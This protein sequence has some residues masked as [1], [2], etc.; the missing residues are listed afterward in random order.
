MLSFISDEIT[1]KYKKKPKLQ[2]NNEDN[3]KNRSTQTTS[4][5][6]IAKKSFSK[7]H[8]YCGCVREKDCQSNYNRKTSNKKSKRKKNY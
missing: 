8:H 4:R 1:M 6:F 2:Y 3:M 7:S 5:D